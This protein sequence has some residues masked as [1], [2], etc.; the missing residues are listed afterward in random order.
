M[1]DLASLVELITDP[2]QTHDVRFTLTRYL[3]EYQAGV[4]FDRVM[5]LAS[6][7]VKASFADYVLPGARFL[8]SDAAYRTAC[9]VHLPRLREQFRAQFAA[10]RASAFV[11]PTTMVPPVPIGQ[12]V[13]VTIRGEKVPFVTAIARNI[14][15][16]STVGLPGLV[17]PAGLTSSGLPVSLEFDGPTGTDR[18]LLAFGLSLER[19]LGRIPAP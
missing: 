5:E 11:F 16:G 18:G 9:E 1:P 7:D 12:D 13:E 6:P 2:I 14:S 4:S 15:P 3:E 19:T 17:L 10:T 8:V